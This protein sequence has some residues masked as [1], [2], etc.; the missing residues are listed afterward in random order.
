MKSYDITFG[1]PES[2]EGLTYYEVKFK[3]KPR[4]ED[5]ESILRSYAPN[6]YEYRSVFIGLANQF[7]G[8]ALKSRF[9]MDGSFCGDNLFFASIILPNG[10]CTQ[11]IP[12]AYWDKLNIPTFNPNKCKNDD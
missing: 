9:A 2:L 12:L 6:I 3:N 1:K 7:A 8:K 11:Y 4:I 5:V 10:L